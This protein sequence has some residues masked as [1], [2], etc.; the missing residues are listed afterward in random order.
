MTTYEKRLKARIDPTKCV[1]CGACI[2]ACPT[3]AIQMLP[4]WVSA[5]QPSRC[6][7][8]GTCAALCHRR[9]SYLTVQ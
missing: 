4:G 1:G 9:A 3:Q 7:G 2:T 5:V 6:I 8:C